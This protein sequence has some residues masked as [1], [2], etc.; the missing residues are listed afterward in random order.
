MEFSFRNFWYCDAWCPFA[1]HLPSHGHLHS[2]HSYKGSIFSTALPDDHFHVILLPMVTFT[3]ATAIKVESLVLRCLMTTFTSSSVHGHLHSCH[4]IVLWYLMMH[5]AYHLPAMVTFTA[6]TAIKVESL[7][8]RCQ[9][10]TFLSRHPP[11]YGHLHSCHIYQSR[12]F[13]AVMPD[14]HLLIL[15]AATAIR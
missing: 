11:A 3:A 1:Y 15:T 10:T 7:V 5:V 2:C 6:A 9:M 12:I 4:N 8:L 13:G 14:A